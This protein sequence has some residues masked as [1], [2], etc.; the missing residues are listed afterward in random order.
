MIDK[1]DLQE[2]IREY[3]PDLKTIDKDTILEL[4]ENTPEVTRKIQVWLGNEDTVPM[5]LWTTDDIT[6]IKIPINNFG[7][8][9]EIT[10]E[11]HYD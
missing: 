3:M 8:D 1:Y 5:R 4:I 2:A 7:K 9:M 6:E 11:E 10:F